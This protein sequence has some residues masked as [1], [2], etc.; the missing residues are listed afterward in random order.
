V[1]DGRPARLMLARD[2]TEREALEAQLRQAQKMEAVGQLA[3]GVAHDFNNLLT[4]IRLHSEL[5]A[6]ALAESD[7]RREDVAEIGRAADRAAALTRQLLAFSRRQVL[8]PRV[9]VLDEVVRN[10]RQL[11]HRVI[12]ADIRVES[13]GTT[14]GRVRADPGQIEQV[15]VNLAVNARDAMPEGGRLLIETADVELDAMFGPKR[16]AAISAGPYV[17]LAVSDTGLGMDAATQARIFEPFFTTKEV[18][19][20][21]GLGLSTVYGIVKQSGGSIWVESEPGA[22][23]TFRIYLPRV[24]ADLASREPA[25]EA[26]HAADDTTR[27]SETILLVEDEDAVRTLAGR[28]LRRKGY[29]VLDARHGGEALEILGAYL[30][31]VDLVLTDIVM[32]GMGGTELARRVREMRPNVPL[33]FMSGYSHGEIEQRGGFAPDEAFLQKPFTADELARQVREVLEAA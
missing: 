19:K 7:P 14:I 11:L 18:G 31:R 21:T 9:L 17:M 22:G 30:G 12:G 16:G 26:V 23:A 8:Q 27:G 28:M 10:A 3:G 13:H 32:P 1:V 25:P 15:L 2:I 29:R 4:V 33:L 20:G 5:L 6:E 24:D